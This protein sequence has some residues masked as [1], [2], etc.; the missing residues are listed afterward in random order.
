MDKDLRDLIENP[1]FLDLLNNLSEYVYITD[2]KGYV[3]FINTAAEKCEHISYAETK[4]K[5]IND[6]YTQKESPTLKAL[7]T[8]K[9]I[10]E[11]E[12]L[13]MI[14]GKQYSQLCK[15]FPLYKDKK[16]IGACTLQRDTTYLNQILSD[17]SS[18]KKVSA[19]IQNLKSKPL[20]L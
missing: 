16:I 9:K 10:D 3:Q 2:N 20:T 5:H 4:G 14:D 7:E 15:S 19:P 8:G 17:N 6:I 12:N 1:I 13:Y 18:L 11:H